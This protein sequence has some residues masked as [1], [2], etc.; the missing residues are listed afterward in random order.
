MKKIAGIKLL[1]GIEYGMD[2]RK[3]KIYCVP[4]PS[5]LEVQGKGNPELSGF[6]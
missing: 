3:T 5:E 1:P 4:R 6:K 2:L